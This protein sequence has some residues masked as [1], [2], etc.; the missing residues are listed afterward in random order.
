MNPPP[1]G[2]PHPGPGGTLPGYP[3]AG[4]PP[5]W[6]R[7]YPTWVPPA[8]YPPWQG[9]PQQDTPG[10]VPPQQGTPPLAA[11]LPSV[12]PVAFWVMLQSIMGYGYPPP[13]DRQI[14]GWKDRCVSKHYLPVVLRTRAVKSPS[15]LSL[16]FPGQWSQVVL[17][18]AFNASHK[19]RSNFSVLDCFLD[20]EAIFRDNPMWRSRLQCRGNG[21]EKQIWLKL[22][23]RKH[24]LQERGT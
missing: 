6:P 22:R 16:G 2:Y 23:K 10:R 12:C 17:K 19:C 13:V 14:D 9:T 18:I 4:Y 7:G 20:P 11:G 21:W 5:S 8:G 24:K 3:P 1:A 15:K